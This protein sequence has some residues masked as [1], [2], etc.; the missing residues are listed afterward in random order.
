MPL[1]LG[2]G[3]LPQ[4]STTISAKLITSLKILQLS[5]EELAQAVRQE[6]TDNPILEIEERET[7]GTCG[8]SLQDG[9]CPECYAAT[10][11][12][13]ASA[14]AEPAGEPYDG[15]SYAD[16]PAGRHD[17]DGDREFDALSLLPSSVSLADYLTQA[18]QAVLPEEAFPIAEYA[19]GS[20]D[21]YGYLSVSSAEIAQACG[22][23]P[24]AVEEVLA[25]L[26]RQ[27]PA[28][29]GSRSVPECL[30]SQLDHLTELGITD[31]HARAI[32]TDCF[33][34]LGEH[35]FQHIAARLHVGL[36]EVLVSRD[37]IR[38]NLTP[39]PALSAWPDEQRISP[40]RSS[41]VR[42]D[43][44]IVPAD[45]GYTVEILE[46]ERYRLQVNHYYQALMRDG[47]DL[48]AGDRAYLVRCTSRAKFFIDC[49]QQRWATLRQITECMVQCQR[50]F[51]DRGVRYLKP[52]TRLEVACQVNL[53]ES[54]V[55][56]ATASKF[57]L[58]PDKRVV[59]F[60]DL[61]DGS[62]AVKDAMRELFE[63]EDG[64]RPMSD[65]QVCRE[66]RERGMFIARRTV[67]KY[68]DAMRVLPSN[69][70]TAM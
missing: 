1:E 16:M 43:V 26:R 12:A 53:H 68:R 35:K 2:Q 31:P 39:F 28:G 44:A 60:D 17:Q 34:D 52:L 11:P 65:Q 22:A 20:L 7:C 41:Y 56:R 67:A 64:R 58:L 24:D 19:I 14:D 9:F 57:I 48:P 66:L 47:E 40:D 33:E 36:A 69:L 62:L 49:I 54:T 61:F 42:P 30:L 8:S 70:R 4:L 5:S 46:A 63:H 55:S 21:D 6:M 59:G 25:A 10:M 45:H 51:L 13:G 3:L 37:F 32:L 23:S 15:S 29:I 18:L 27:E 38:T 50:D